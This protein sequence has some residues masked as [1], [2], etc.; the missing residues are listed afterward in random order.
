MNSI[1][2]IAYFCDM[3]NYGGRCAGFICDNVR[4]LE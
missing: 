1:S 3:M 2:Y 4:I